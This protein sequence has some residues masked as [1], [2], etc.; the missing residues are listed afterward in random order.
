VRLADDALTAESTLVIE[1]ASH[2]D[3]RGLPIQ[4]RELGLPE[5]F[6]LVKSGGACVLVHERTGRRFPLERTECVES[7]STG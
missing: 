5:R 7:G 4:G 6:H 3:A 1:R 2:R